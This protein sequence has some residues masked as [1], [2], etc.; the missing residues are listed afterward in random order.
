MSHAIAT[1]PECL[2]AP[3]EVCLCMLSRREYPRGNSVSFLIIASILNILPVSHT[4][5]WKITAASITLC[6]LPFA[7]G[8]HTGSWLVLQVVFD[9]LRWCCKGSLQ[10]KSQFGLFPEFCAKS[11]Y[12]CS[13]EEIWIIIQAREASQLEATKKT[14]SWLKH[15]RMHMLLQFSSFCCCAH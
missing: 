3:E 8:R 14:F 5:W 2:F 11:S 13:L 15:Q 12:I 6:M 1:N 10:K 9:N 7:I 4:T